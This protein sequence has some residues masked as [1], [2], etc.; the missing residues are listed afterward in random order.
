MKTIRIL[1]ASILLAVTPV[2]F[3]GCA[4]TRTHEAVVYDSFKS[5]YNA[6]YSAYTAWLTIVVKGQASKEK[7]LKVDAA[8]NEFRASFSLAFQGAA[9]DWNAAS[10]EQVQLLADKLIILIHSL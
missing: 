9:L 4:T 1:I 7:E 8:W 6:A 2:M 10:P 3:T 5:T